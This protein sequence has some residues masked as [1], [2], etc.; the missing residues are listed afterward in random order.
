VKRI[1]FKIETDGIGGLRLAVYNDS[2]FKYNSNMY[3][4][5]FVPEC[6]RIS[7]DLNA[8]GCKYSNINGEEVDFRPID[9]EMA[10]FS[11]SVKNSSYFKRDA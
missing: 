8:E 2:N 10:I 6:I 9:V 11:W 4:T 3:L 7:N 1:N 5:E